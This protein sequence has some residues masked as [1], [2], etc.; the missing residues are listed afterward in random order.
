MADT[1][2]VI[3]NIRVGFASSSPVTWTPITKIL[4]VKL[5][6]KTTADVDTT[7]FSSSRFRTNISGFTEISA[8]ELTLLADMKETNATTG[9]VQKTLW[10]LQISQADVYVRY[11]ITADS[12]DGEWSGFE[13]GARV[14]SWEPAGAVGDKLTL[15]VVF[16]NVD[17]YFNR[18]DAGA[19]ELS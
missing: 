9:T 5:P 11:E 14:G 10:D 19:S 8:L 16:K 13:F 6:T 12:A 1:T 2:G 4:D 7:V 18:F 3:S 15:K 17:T